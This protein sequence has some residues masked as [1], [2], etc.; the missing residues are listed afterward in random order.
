MS[1]PYLAA[2]REAQAEALR[3]R[4]SAK[5]VAAV[6]LLRRFDEFGGVLIALVAWLVAH[7]P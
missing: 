1:I 2:I 4:A 7:T 3:A 5:L 6:D